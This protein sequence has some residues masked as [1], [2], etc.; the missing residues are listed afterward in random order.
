MTHR[1]PFRRSA[2]PAAFLGLAIV[3]GSAACSAPTSQS[4]DPTSA[5]TT[6]GRMAGAYPELEARIPST[7]EGR[8]PDRLDSGR[9]CTPSN[10]GSLAAAGFDEVRFAGGTWDFGGQRAAALVVF[11][12]DGLTADRIAEFYAAS[13]D[14]ADR[15]QVTGI[16]TPT[17][18]GRPG[19]RLDTTTGSRTQT[20]VVWPAAEPDVVNVVITNDLPDPKIDAAVDAFGGR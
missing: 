15:T 14:A 3:S 12:A 11:T 16:S 6:D 4:F 1:P 20:V 10:L 17:L 18:A 5:C 13:A 2:L 19:H 8:G 9:H 7:Y